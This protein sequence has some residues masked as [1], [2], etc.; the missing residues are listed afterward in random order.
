VTNHTFVR[1]VNEAFVPLLSRL[2]FSSE[3]PVLR[4]RFNS[5]SFLRK[6]Y[7]VDVSYEPGDEAIII[8]V[9]RRKDGKLSDIDDP[10]NT[11]RLDTLKER[12]MH[13]VTREE[14]EEGNV[15][16]GAVRATDPTEQLMVKSA[17]ELA[18][19][20]PKYLADSR[21]EAP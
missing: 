20:L 18:L 21:Q 5:A 10:A 19:V 7:V 2:G 1:I 3:A 17:R 9:L 6:D 4:G 8:M 12:Y 11:V 16:F 15:A 14:F 13:L